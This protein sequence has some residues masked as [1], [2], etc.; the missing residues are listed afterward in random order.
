VSYLLVMALSVED[1]REHER[2]LLGHYLEVQQALGGFDIDFDTAFRSHSIHAAY[3]V[4]ASCQI[5]TFPEKTTPARET[6]ARAFLSRA[7][8]GWKTSTCARRFATWG[9]S[10]LPERVTKE[11]ARRSTWRA[12]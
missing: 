8:A 6:F 12:H 7:E 10:L 4:P 9:S 2:R 11:S 5:V 3:G 1:R